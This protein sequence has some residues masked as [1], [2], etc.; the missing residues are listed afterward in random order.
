M[1]GERVLIVDDEAQIRRALRTAL[2]GHGYEV[3]LAE[4]GE[5]ALTALAARVPD[6]VVLDLMMPGVDGFEVLQQTRAWSRVPIIVLSTIRDATAGGLKWGMIA[7]HT[8]GH[9][10]RSVAHRMGQVRAE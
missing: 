6:V 5:S 4:E 1:S 9:A 10:P 2:T 8:A 3:E 7:A